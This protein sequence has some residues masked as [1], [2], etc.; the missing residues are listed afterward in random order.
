LPQ[1]ECSTQDVPFD[2]DPMP[3]QGVVNEAMPAQEAQA[4]VQDAQTADVP[5]VVQ[6]QCGPATANANDTRVLETDDNNNDDV[7]AVSVAADTPAVQDFPSA[8]GNDTRVRESDDNNNDNVETVSAADVP[9]HEYSTA[10]ANDG[11]VES[12]D[13]NDNA[14]AVSV[15]DV[16][17]E[18]SSTANAD[19]VRVESDENNDNANAPTDMDIEEEIDNS[20]EPAARSDVAVAVP[21]T[22]SI[23]SHSTTSLAAE[24]P[25]SQ[26]QQQHFAKSVFA[27]GTIVQ[28]QART[29]PGVNKHGGVARITSVHTSSDGSVKYNVRYVLGGGGEKELEEIFVSLYIDERGTKEVDEEEEGIGASVARKSYRLESK[30]DS[31]PPA[32]LAKCE[33]DGYDVNRVAVPSNTESGVRRLTKQFTLENT[34]ANTK[35]LNANQRS[36]KRKLRTADSGP[37]ASKE[38][39]K[40]AAKNAPGRRKP[41]DTAPVVAKGSSKTLN[42]SAANKRKSAASLGNAKGKKRKTARPSTVASE[43]IQLA[44]VAATLELTNEQKCE[45]ADALYMDSIRAAMQK[46]LI[47]VATSGLSETDTEALKKLCKGTK[48]NDGTFLRYHRA[49]QPK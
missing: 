10:N 1:E 19:D 41:R 35:S 37:T 28:V 29:W 11:R 23:P 47:S 33:A 3:M 36:S 21:A 31:I 27:V 42:K 17:V 26:Q 49:M 43:G 40:P 30:E 44:A 16:P 48:N 7:Q 15:A 20:S 46:G 14:E 5:V 12:D 4:D 45:S 38:N 32:V 2:E 13:N 24:T 34:S 9:V 25:A 39:A 8:N 18:G 6:E 22:S